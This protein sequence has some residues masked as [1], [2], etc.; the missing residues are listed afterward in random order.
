MITIVWNPRGF[1]LIH[2][3]PSRRKCNNSYH[4]R[5]RKIFEPLSEWR[6]GQAGGAGRKLKID[7]PCQQHTPAHTTAASQEFMEEN[8][9]E[10][11]IH[12]PYSPHLAPSDFHLFKHVKHCLR[13]QSFEAADELFLAIDAVLKGTEKG[14]QR[15]DPSLS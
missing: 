12:P 13:G 4:R 5:A 7:R 8:G 9:L 15:I 1:Y 11:A 3:L 6:C 14:N 2:V 10:R